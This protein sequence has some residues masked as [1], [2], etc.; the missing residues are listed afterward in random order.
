MDRR[1]A[2]TAQRERTC[3]TMLLTT[4]RMRAWFVQKANTKMWQAN[5]SAKSALLDGITRKIQ[6]LQM[7]T[8]RAPGVKRGI[9]QTWRVCL[10]AKRAHMDI[11]TER[12]NRPALLPANYVL[13]VN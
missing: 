1:L 6:T 5:P 11:L 10:F 3:L 9:M 12:R 4:S 2:Q 8:K 13:E 7:R